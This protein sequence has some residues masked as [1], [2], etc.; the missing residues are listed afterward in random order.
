MFIDQAVIQVKAGDGG[1]GSVSF[2]REKYV[3]KGGPDGG[4]GGHGGDVVLVADENVNTLLDFRGTFHW[5]AVS[6]EAGRAKQQTGADGAACIIRMPP[7]T[8]VYDNRDERLLCDLGPGDSIVIAR[9]GKGGWG[10]EHFK[11]STN[12]APRQAGPGEPGEER[13]L[14]LELKLIA[15]AGIIGL[16]N[17]GKS[18][19]L[20]AVTEA[21]PKIA[22]Y[23]FTTVHAQLGIAPLDPSRR[24]VLADIPGLIEGASHGAGLGHD[25]LRHIERTRVI[26]HLLDAAPIDGTSPADNYRMVRQEL[27]QHSALLAEKDELIVLNK[28]DL[29]PTQ[30][31]RDAAVARLRRDLQLGHQVGVLAISAA[32]GQGTRELIERVWGMLNAKVQLWRPAAAGALPA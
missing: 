18:T 2:R 20:G 6:G 31:E 11:R 32:T 1:R 9:G 4:N 7:G 5:K 28:M 10:N 3:P 17:A 23:P 19:L 27:A 12:Q 29:L 24:I 26:V 22:D 16:P 13:E 25:F 14:R 21:T 30:A 15:D 8:M